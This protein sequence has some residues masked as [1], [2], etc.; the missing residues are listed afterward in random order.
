VEI[1]GYA[2]KLEAVDKRTGENY[3]ADRATIT[4]SRDGTTIATLQPERR[5]FTVQRRVTSHTAIRTNL[6]SDVYVALG[7]PD[8][9][10]S[11]VVRAYWKPLVPWIWIGAGLMAIG[12]L[13]G[14]ADRRWRVARPVRRSRRDDAPGAAPAHAAE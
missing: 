10:G 13:T 11:W 9:S 3:L 4:L 1:G 7:D 14:L 2:L 6:L 12:G 8:P 5:L